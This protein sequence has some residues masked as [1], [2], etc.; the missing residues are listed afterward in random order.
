[1][2][3]NLIRRVWEHKNHVVLGFTDK[4]DIAQ[5]VYFEVAD[6][7]EAAIRRE[8]RLKFWL[9]KWKVDLIEKNNPSWCDL[10]DEICGVVDT[11]VK[12]QY[13]EVVN[14]S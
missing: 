2:T 9:R 8:K 7:A 4:Y 5:L 10:Y 6:T 12:P 1:M 3:S 13:D 11:A 14:A